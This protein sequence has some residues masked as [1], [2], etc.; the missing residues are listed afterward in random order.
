[1]ASSRAREASVPDLL[2]RNENRP[3]SLLSRYFFIVTGI[4]TTVFES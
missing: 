1:M 3:R 4:L 2:S